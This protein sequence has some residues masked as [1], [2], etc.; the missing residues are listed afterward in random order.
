MK[1]N[2]PG[3]SPLWLISLSL[4]LG[5][6]IVA[7][8]PVSISGGETIKANDWIGFAGSVVGSVVTLIAAAMAWFSLRG[9]I[10]EQRAEREI[11]HQ[12]AKLAATLILAQALHAASALARANKEAVDGITIKSSGG[13]A[14]V[15]YDAK[16]N[17]KFDALHRR[18]PQL[19][20]ALSY[21]PVMDIWKDLD[22]SNK[23]TYLMI[24]STLHTMININ[25]N[26]G[27]NF[28]RYKAAQARHSG[29]LRIK[30]YLSVFDQ[31]LAKTFERD[32]G[33]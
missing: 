22:I 30:D 32:C 13:T 8:I 14:E 21:P 20:S 33:F 4:A 25:S 31:K 11:G 1:Q 7:L 16:L 19:E 3:L 12:E 17:A 9:Q 23:A 15:G 29:F 10:D 24:V 26:R 18:F 6:T 2:L 28:D 5:T 27:A